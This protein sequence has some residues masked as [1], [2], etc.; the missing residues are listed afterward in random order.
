[1]SFALSITQ[2]DIIHQIKL[3][4]QLPEIVFEI[5]NRK[6]LT[7]NAENLAIEISPQELQQEADAFRFMNGLTTANETWKWL[8]NH[9]LSIEEFEEI[10][11]Q[12]ILS[13]KLADK[14]FSHQVEPYFFAHQL[15]YTKVV[16]YQIT[17]EDPDLALEL[18]Y[19]IR[20][21]ETSFYDVAHNY[22]S[23]P[24]LRRKGGYQGIQNRQDL[25]PEIAA[26]VFASN[27]PELLS[28]IT[29]A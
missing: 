21:G 13:F 16:M 22:I 3:S 27:P 24:E 9:H 11:H 18:F 23:D 7:N 14:L 1:M 6:I 29:T 5:V 20:E 28:P 4:R 19:A 10:A 2:E 15:D 26:A 12:N 17:L 25:H 8:E